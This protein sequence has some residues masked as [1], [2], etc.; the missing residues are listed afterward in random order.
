[1]KDKSKKSKDKAVKPSKTQT[2]DDDEEYLPA[3]NI[4]TRKRTKKDED[5]KAKMN[6]IEEEKFSAYISDCSS[7]GE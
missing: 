4:K 5:Q 3:S 7:V 6:Q 1:M 2:F